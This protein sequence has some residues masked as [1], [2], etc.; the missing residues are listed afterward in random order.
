MRYLVLGLLFRREEWN[1]MESRLKDKNSPLLIN[2]TGS[3]LSIEVL[4]TF[5]S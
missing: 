1:G 5:F 3:L 4:G 2:P